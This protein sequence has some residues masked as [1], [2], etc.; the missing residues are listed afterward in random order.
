LF[1]IG[2]KHFYGL[3]TGLTEKCYNQTL[4][5]GCKQIAG[6][7]SQRQALEPL[8][9]QAL[10]H[11]VA[12]S[13]RKGLLLPEDVKG[14]IQHCAAP[15]SPSRVK[16][17]IREFE[18]AGLLKMVYKGHQ[19]RYRVHPE[20]SGLA[21]THFARLDRSKPS[22]RRVSSFVEFQQRM[23]DQAT[24]T[25][26]QLN[27][28]FP[29]LRLTA[30]DQMLSR[31]IRRGLLTKVSGGGGRGR[32]A[33]VPATWASSATQEGAIDRLEAALTFGGEDSVFCY[34]TAMELH[35]LCRY[36]VLSVIY[37]SGGRSFRRRKAGGCEYIWVNRPNSSLGIAVHDHRGNPIQVSDI[38][39]TLID[40]LHRPR[41][42]LGAEDILRAVD[43]IEA[44][45]AD[46]TLRYLRALR[47]PALVA[48][49]GWV[50]YCNR[51]RWNIPAG[52][53]GALRRR[54]PKRPVY[55][56]PGRSSRL[57]PQWAL[58]VPLELLGEL[59]GASDDQ[60]LPGKN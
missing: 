1:I 16:E 58:R 44:L 46:K 60:H 12:E 53:F 49:V 59:K 47:S 38:E 50:M 8:G 7:D 10:P 30:M 5:S 25:R 15:V 13:R 43:L 45:D 17:L 54:L 31:L 39:R 55:L 52:I 57:V 37:L 4:V 3:P 14:L 42:C 28:A 19:R 2:C 35:R 40:M 6:S 20:N 41:Y 51:D 23:G 21:R 34:A 48:K 11:L 9:L 18:R 36:D 32:Y 29:E 26:T 33:I 56:F 27:E 24:F 22:D